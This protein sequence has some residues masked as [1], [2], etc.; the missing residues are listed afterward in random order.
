MRVAVLLLI[1]IEKTKVYI[2]N[3]IRYIIQQVWLKWIRRD[4]RWCEIGTITI[5]FIPI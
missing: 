1:S 2:L 4:L 3:I 5:I